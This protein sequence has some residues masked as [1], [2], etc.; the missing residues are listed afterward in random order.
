MFVS[1]EICLYHL[2]CQIYSPKFIDNVTEIAESAFDGCQALKY[3]KLPAGISKISQFAFQFCSSLSSIEIPDN[4]TE[5]EN[6]AFFHCS[7]L[8]DVTLSENLKTIGAN[9]FSSCEKLESI[10]I[11]KNVTEIHSWAFNGC[12]GL[13]TVY[14]KPLTPP[15]SYSPFDGIDGLIIYVPRN[16]VEQYKEA[17]YSVESQI[18]GYDF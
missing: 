1:Q 11:P 14:C 2:S 7:N 12:S 5:I 3:V 6:S 4:V 16:S 15:S 10:T 8:T 17:W 18:Q 13:Q 9:A